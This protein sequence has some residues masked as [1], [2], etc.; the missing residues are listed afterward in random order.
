MCPTTMPKK[1]KLT[2][3][4]C[5]W[6]RERFQNAQFVTILM[7]VAVLASLN[8][9]VELDSGSKCSALL[10]NFVRLGRKPLANWRETKEG[11]DRTRSHSTRE[12]MVVLSQARYTSSTIAHRFH[13]FRCERVW[14]SSHPRVSACQCCID[15]PYFRGN[16]GLIARC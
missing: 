5:L 14:P 9:H 4:T 15:T 8:G 11:G 3:R 16:G 7:V 10:T 1:H 2:V 6:L 12:G 13:T